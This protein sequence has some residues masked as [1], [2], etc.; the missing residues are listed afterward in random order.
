MIQRKK[1]TW[2][3]TDSYKTYEGDVGK[4]KYIKVLKD[5]FW[6]VSYIMIRE[7]YEFNMPKLGTIAIRRALSNPNFR[8]RDID[9]KF[10]KDTGKIKVITNTHTDGYYF[11]YKWLKPRGISKFRSSKFYKFEAIR[12]E[13]KLIGKRGL[14]N[15]IKR[16]AEDPRLK[17]YTTL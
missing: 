16:C 2:T 11:F 13:D 12:G 17:D 14:A 9:Y 6:E 8:K 7:K 1:T 15:W 5:F 10:Y 4:E 3:I